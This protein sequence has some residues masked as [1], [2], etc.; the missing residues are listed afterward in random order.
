MDELPCRSQPRYH[1]L[2]IELVL[3][4]CLERACLIPS[5]RLTTW[6]PEHGKAHAG[7]GPCFNNLNN[8]RDYIA[9]LPLVEPAEVYGL[10]E[11]AK[12]ALELGETSR[13][14]GALASIEPRSTNAIGMALPDVV[15]QVRLCHSSSLQWYISLSCKVTGSFSPK[16]LPHHSGR[17]RHE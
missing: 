8:G 1:Y 6:Q 2:F 10:H 15:V 12:L 3:N 11:N 16:K 14:L 9:S 4:L 5:S 7:S 13:L 17:G